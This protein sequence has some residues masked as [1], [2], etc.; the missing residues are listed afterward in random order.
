MRYLFLI[1]LALIMFSMTAFATQYNISPSDDVYVNE[2]NPTSNYNSQTSL[3]VSN[4]SGTNQNSFIRF[5]LSTYNISNASKIENALLTLYITGIPYG[6]EPVAIMSLTN[7][8]IAYTWEDGII[9]WDTQP[10][11]LFYSYFVN[12]SGT[13][14]CN[15]N[16]DYCAF[17]NDSLCPSSTITVLNLTAFLKSEINSGRTDIL[18]F[19]L[20]KPTF[21]SNIS[22]HTVSFVST[23]G[24]ARYRPFITMDIIN[25][26]PTYSNENPANE[27]TGIILQPT[28]SF[29]LNDT[30]SSTDNVTFFNADDN[31][32]LCTNNSAVANSQVSCYWDAVNNYS[33]IYS[34]YANI[35]DEESNVTT[36]TYYFTTL[37][38]QLP[39]IANEN[40]ADNATGIIR[41]P[42]LS[43][44]V[45]DTD[46]AY[47][48]VTFYNTTDYSIIC[49]NNSISANSTVNCYWASA[50]DYNN[51]YSW[52]VS[53]WDGFNNVSSTVY[54]FTTETTTTTSTTTTSTSTTTTSSTT[55]SSTTTTASTTTSTVPSTTTT[56]EAPT[57]E[58]IAV[59]GYISA[60]VV[61][62]FA[63]LFFFII[64]SP[65]K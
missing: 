16:G 15:T 52:R 21:N 45:N 50:D 33:T 60:L 41:S 29:I 14:C 8:T 43:V 38:N 48:N 42:T 62:F 39:V 53:V 47:L 55:T 54:T 51:P 5:N 63:G 64:K 19:A 13:N 59:E 20:S 56:I 18:T 3:K 40:P 17:Y 37:D 22:V 26:A 30:D 34:W 65:F 28:V 46:S 35:I 7:D 36:P 9:T 12:G 44:D 11:I 23:E 25:D 24:S 32:V 58:V 4:N 27:S 10:D 2:H 31:T 57:G 1:P 49:F 6:D 61:L